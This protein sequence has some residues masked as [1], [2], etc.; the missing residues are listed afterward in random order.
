[1]KKKSRIKEIMKDDDL[2]NLS[3]VKRQNEF[4][5]ELIRN[6]YHITRT[7]KKLDMHP[8]VYYKWLDTDKKFAE[9]IRKLRDCE[10]DLIEDAFRDLVKQRNPSA[11]IFGLKTRGAH[12]GYVEKQQI[13]HF[14]STGIMIKFED[15]NSQ[16]IIDVT[17]EESEEQ[18][19]L[20]DESEDK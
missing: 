18:K 2:K 6:D 4:I 7:V 17:L 13:E 8:G 12:R 3:R 9:K 14:G 10:I 16:K 1:M 20:P 5:N 15:P 19:Q 11:V